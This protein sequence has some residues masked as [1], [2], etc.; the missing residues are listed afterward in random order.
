MTEKGKGT[1]SPLWNLKRIEH[2]IVQ[3]TYIHEKV[4]QLPFKS[5]SVQ[6]QG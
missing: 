3:W 4:A 2:V 5:T 1:F 6:L